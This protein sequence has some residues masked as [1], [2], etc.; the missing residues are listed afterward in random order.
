MLASKLALY[1]HTVRYLKPSQIYRR[2][3]FRLA[4]KHVDSSPHPELRPAEPVWLTPAHRRQSLLSGNKFNL[5]NELGNLC[6]LGWNGPE[7]CKL[8]RYNQHYFDDLNAINAADRIDWHH[9]LIKSWIIENQPG[10]GIGWESYPTSLRIV[11]WVKWLLVGR[12][13]DCDYLQS[14]AIQARWLSKQIEWHILGNHLFANA[15]ALVFAG[16]YFQG[17]EARKWLAIGLNIITQELSEQVLPDGGNFELSPMYHT[18]FLEDLLDLINLASVYPDIIGHEQVNQWRETAINMLGWLKT[19]CHPD[20]EISFFNDAAIGVAPSPAEIMAY[21]C[22]LGIFTNQLI[23]P[24]SH[25]NIIRL[26][27]SGYIRLNSMK[28]VVLLDVASIGPDYLPGH[29]HADTLSFELSLFDERV[30]VNG[31]TSQYGNGPIRQ[32]ERATQAHNTLVIDGKSSSEVWSGFRV[33]R[34]AYP[35]DLELEQSDQCIFVSCVHDGYKRLTGKVLH[36]RSWQISPGKLIIR[37]RVVGKFKTAVAY[38]HIHPNIK[39]AAIDSKKYSLLLQSSGKKISLIVMN[40]NASIEQGFFSPEF[41]MRLKGKYLA[42]RLES[43]NDAVV[44]I[45]WSDDD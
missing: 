19:M 21:A 7:R 35:R 41:G 30:L 22:R 28:A 26:M 9:T 1:I 3:W 23:K 4:F 10:Q 32:E 42:V 17:P 29:A 2:L 36:K 8:W 39:V 15:K 18:I 27:H 5:L 14:L 24:L 13:L 45:S 37:D 33:A 6:D 38:Y 34:R 44:E 43:D 12:S 11:N 40:G 16:L 20:G 25:L 31:G